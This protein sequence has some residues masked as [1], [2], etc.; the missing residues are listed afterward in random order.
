MTSPRSVRFDAEVLR[1]LERYVQDHPGTSISS[2][3][4]L[5]V[6]EALRSDDH[7]GI[8]FR[9]GPTGRRAG[10]AAGPDVWEVIATLHV[11]AGEDPDVSGDDLAQATAEASGMQIGQVRAAVRYYA[12]YRSEIDER[13]AANEAAAEQ[14]EA[15]WRAERDL[16]R[17]RAS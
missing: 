14:A 7:P 4:N 16:L 13:I 6:D 9:A 1:R 11:V 15:A 17:G 5:L 8:V 10:L 12:A 3:A 2:M